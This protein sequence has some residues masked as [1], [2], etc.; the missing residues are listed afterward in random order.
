M[1]ASEMAEIATTNSDGLPPNVFLHPSHKV[2]SRG[3][4]MPHWEQ[5]GAFTGC[6]KGFT[7]PFCGN[8]C[9]PNNSRPIPRSPSAGSPAIR[10]RRAESDARSNTSYSAPWGGS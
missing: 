1:H 2:A 10:A 5:R 6:P 3:I 7:Q 9:S 8:Y 4:G